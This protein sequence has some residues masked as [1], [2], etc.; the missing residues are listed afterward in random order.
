VAA[1]VL[2]THPT[3]GR[4]LSGAVAGDQALHELACGGGGGGGDCVVNEIIRRTG[5]A[6]RI[7]LIGLGLSGG[8]EAGDIRRT[9]SYPRGYHVIPTD[10]TQSPDRRIVSALS[11]CTHGPRQESVRHLWPNA[12]NRIRVSGLKLECRGVL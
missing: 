8:V 4:R 10:V 7:E 2:I 6:A 3:E 9:L 12:Q 1:T 5:Y 11:P